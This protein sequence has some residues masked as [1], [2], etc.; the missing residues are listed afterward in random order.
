MKI[1]ELCDSV[2]L[3][4]VNIDDDE[5]VQIFLGGLGSSPSTVEPY[6]GAVRSSPQLYFRAHMLNIGAR[7]L[8]PVKPSG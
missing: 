8:L 7:Q 2:G 4:N 6:L 5:M 1:K 3:I